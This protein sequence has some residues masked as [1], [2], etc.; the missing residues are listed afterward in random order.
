MPTAYCLL[1]TADCVLSSQP[2]PGTCR[3][4]LQ[5]IVDPVEIVE[6]PGHRGDLD[7]LS[8][9]VVRAQALEKI[10]VDGV[11]I[12]GELPGPGQRRLFRFTE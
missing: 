5:S 9:V 1:L 12:E 4:H 2:F 6:Q 11:R 10:V 3:L 7:D 8:L